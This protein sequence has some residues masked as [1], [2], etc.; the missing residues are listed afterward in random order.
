MRLVMYIAIV[1]TF[2]LVF[3]ASSHAASTPFQVKNQYGVSLE[4]YLS[5]GISTPSIQPRDQSGGDGQ[6]TKA[7]TKDTYTSSGNV[8]GG[9]VW[10]TIP[11]SG[12]LNLY[13]HR[14]RDDFNESFTTF[15][16]G[17]PSNAPAYY[18]TSLAISPVN[19]VLTIQDETLQPV[20]VGLDSFESDIIYLVNEY[21]SQLG[22]P[23]LMIDERLNI[24]ADSH[25]YHLQNSGWTSTSGIYAHCGKGG[26]YPK[27]REKLTGYKASNENYGYSEVIWSGALS[28]ATGKSIVDKYKSSSDHWNELMNPSYVCVGIGNN[29]GGN[30]VITLGGSLSSG[31]C[32]TSNTGQPRYDACEQKPGYQTN[33][34]DCSSIDDGGDDSD[35]MDNE[36]FTCD[37]N[38]STPDDIDTIVKKKTVLGLST[39]TYRQRRLSGG[40]YQYQLRM[41]GTLKAG[42]AVVK[43]RYVTLYRR[44][45]ARKYRLC[46]AKTNAR[47]VF[48]CKRT[49]RT[50]PIII[51]RAYPK[52]QGSFT[53]DRYFKPSFRV[54]KRR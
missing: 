3:T 31:T 41:T 51:K 8:L 50:K 54:V 20:A 36:F 24:A 34:S 39:R 13:F 48:I 5:T 1:V 26:S 4:G 40:R 14:L 35:C 43:N 52:I 23:K 38:G 30:N 16:D 47:G 37:D 18:P 44:V 33:I 12:N 27:T 49:L 42:R 22:R 25:A 32:T 45:G 10:N 21:R 6:S 46:R 17:C 15:V 9:G 19:Q 28:N 7:Y 29:N 2:Y 11:S 53:G